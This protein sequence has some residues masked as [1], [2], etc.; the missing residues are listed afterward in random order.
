MN[1][2][3]KTACCLWQTKRQISDNNVPIVA[4]YCPCVIRFQRK[5]ISTHKLCAKTPRL[6]IGSCPFPHVPPVL[7]VYRHLGVGDSCEAQKFSDTCVEKLRTLARR[8]WR[9][10]DTLERH[11]PTPVRPNVCLQIAS[12]PLHLVS[13]HMEST[14]TGFHKSTNKIHMKRKSVCWKVILLKNDKEAQRRA[15]VHRRGSWSVTEGQ[16]LV[17]WCQ[18]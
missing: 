18:N 15:N 16:F 12:S 6:H 14:K 13:R 10:N 2:K 5:N 7:Q 11:W 4:H 8:D 17:L 1:V 9:P 3:L